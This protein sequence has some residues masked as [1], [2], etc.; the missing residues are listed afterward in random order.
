MA[1]SALT[2]V[3]FFDLGNTL[4]FTNAS[5]QLQRYADELDTLQVLRGRGYRL[6]LLSNQAS[7]TTIDPVR[8]LLA[9]VGL[10]DYIE[11]DLIR[12]II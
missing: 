3:I 6:G 1:N 7:G 9:G 10:A 4:A 8:A 11:S 2:T 5:G 12:G